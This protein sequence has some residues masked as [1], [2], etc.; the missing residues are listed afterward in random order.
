MGVTVSHPPKMGPS[1]CRKTGSGLPLIRHYGELYNYFIIYY[2]VIIIEI[3][4]TINV[5]CLNHPKTIPLKLVHGKTVF[6][7]T[8]PW[9][10][11]G[12]GL[13][14]YVINIQNQLYFYGVAMNNSKM[15]LRK[16][17]IYNSMKKNKI[18]RNKSNKIQ[19][20]YLKTT[21]HC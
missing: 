16:H 17:S 7:E 2:N 4:C 10:Q 19:V 20:L 3:K 6:R 15:K 21:K 9:C 18:L 13:L 12:W 5:T 1:S 14:G 8:G 11:K